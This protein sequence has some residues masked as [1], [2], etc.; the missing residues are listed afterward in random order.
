MKDLK[1][2]VAIMVNNMQEAIPACI[3]SVNWTDGIYIFNDHCTDNSISLAKK[4]ATTKIHIED[5]PFEKTAF[6]Q[7]ELD[8]RNYII[9]KAFEILGVDSLIL[10]DAD[11]LI[12]DI[13]KPVIVS[14]FS[15]DK[16]DRIAFNIW[17]LYNNKEYIHLWET[18]INNVIM[19]DPHIR[20]IKKGVKF[21]PRFSDGS[22]P[23][24]KFSESTLCLQG[25]YH[26]HLKYL[27]KLHLPNYSFHFLSKFFTKKEV[28]PF[29]RKINF[30][31]PQDIKK[32]LT[33]V[34][35]NNSKN[36]EL[37]HHEE[38]RTKLSNPVDV[39]VHPRDRK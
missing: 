9:D 27:K 2:G 38:V 19:I 8:T 20:V 37:K 23:G 25:A 36:K 1:I 31:L 7:S 29:L 30:T 3:S 13:I 39:L 18:S 34:K 24:I 4:F 16:F 35:N 15:G 21:Q 26:Y 11:E 14:A 32:A 10:L 28:S 33:L 17:H 12:A 22:H 6:E 5:S